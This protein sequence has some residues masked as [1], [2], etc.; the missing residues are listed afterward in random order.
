MGQRFEHLEYLVHGGS[1]SPSLWR[2][3]IIEL[4]LYNV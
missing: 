3:E 4:S 2:V 1:Q